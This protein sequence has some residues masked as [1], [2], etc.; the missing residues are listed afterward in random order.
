MNSPSPVIWWRRALSEVPGLAAVAAVVLAIFRP[1]LGGALLVTPE[2]ATNVSDMLNVSYPFRLLAGKAMA[3]GHLPLWTDQF[4]C[5]YPLLANPAVGTFYP[6]NWLFAFLSGPVAMRAVILLT[7]L[8][9]GWFSYYYARVL[10]LDRVPA[11]L[12]GISFAACGF[13]VNH[14]KHTALGASACWLPLFFALV[15]IAVRER[16]KAGRRAVLWLVPAVAL[17]FAA[18]GVQMLYLS[19]LGAGV[20][21]AIRLARQL[22]REWRWRL[23]RLVALVGVMV[24]GLSLAAV[25]AL[26]SLQ[27]SQHSERAGGLDYGQAD[28]VPMPGR[29]LFTLFNAHAVGRAS[30]HSYNAHYRDPDKPGL[31]W[32]DYIYTGLPAVLLA[33][34]GLPWTWRRRPPARVLLALGAVGILMA[35]DERGGLFPIA[36]QTLPGLSLFRFPERF[37]LWTEFAVAILGAMGAQVL[38]EW[39]RGHARV[40]VST[41]LLVAAA[42]DLVIVGTPQNVY[43]PAEKWLRPPDT[44]TTIRSTPQA[45]AVSVR[46]YYSEARYYLVFRHGGWE[47]HLDDLYADRALLDPT[48]NA[49]WSVPMVDGYVELVPESD[50]KMWSSQHGSPVLVEWTDEMIGPL[51]GRGKL[52]GP[53]GG[54]LHGPFGRRERSVHYESLAAAIRAAARVAHARARSSLS[55]FRR[56]R[57][58][59]PRARRNRRRLRGGLP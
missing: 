6:P 57:P 31:F 36:F 37:L 13:F 5:G 54:R 34:G 11:T 14:A 23:V 30:D 3:A 50:A 52:P 42:V 44:V 55:K 15:E 25:Q 38:L 18:G 41:A 29:D 46:T 48:E 22:S 49:I 20:Y 33:L 4:L 53:T 59:L 40:A 1:L 32:E 39:L 19:L 51:G 47:A 21:A 7:C 10:G 12:A 24:W 16:G 56:A 2:A 26:P 9:A 17:S 28:P 8:M 45:R 58:R 43:Y 35:L 27:L